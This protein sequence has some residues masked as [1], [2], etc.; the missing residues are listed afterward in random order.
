[1]QMFYGFIKVIKVVVNKKGEKQY[2]ENDNLNTTNISNGT[3][4]DWM[5]QI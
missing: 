3:E 1:M 2:E 4:F 5:R